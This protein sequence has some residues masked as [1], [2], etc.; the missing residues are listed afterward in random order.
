M[1][2]QRWLGIPASGSLLLALLLV[3]LGPKTNFT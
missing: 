1:G 2:D 3:Q